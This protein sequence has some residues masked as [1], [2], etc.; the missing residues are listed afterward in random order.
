M[1]ILFLLDKKTKNS[2]NNNCQKNGPLAQL[3]RAADS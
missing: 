1:I 2:Y 3:A